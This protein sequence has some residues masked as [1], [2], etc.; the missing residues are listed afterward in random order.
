ML[1][2]FLGLFSGIIVCLYI[3]YFLKP[4]TFVE[5]FI[6]YGLVFSII[7]FLFLSL[8]IFH[9]QYIKKS[10]LKFLT[11]L[12]FIGLFGYFYSYFISHFREIKIQHKFFIILSLLFVFIHIL[13]ELCGAFKS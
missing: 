10:P 2:I 4:S 1:P 9:Y 3:Q 8:K 6:V 13:L 5:P 12:L 11:E 7:V